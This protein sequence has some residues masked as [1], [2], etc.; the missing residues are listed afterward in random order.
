MRQILFSVA[1]SLL[2]GAAEAH[3]LIASMRRRCQPSPFQSTADAAFIPPSIYHPQSLSLSPAR[4]ATRASSAASKQTAE[5]ATRRKGKAKKVKQPLPPRSLRVRTRVSQSGEELK[6]Y[7]TSIEKKVELQKGPDWVHPSLRWLSR[8]TLDRLWRRVSN[9]EVLLTTGKWGVEATHV[10]SLRDLVRSHG[11]VKVK[12]NDVKQLNST[13]TAIQLQKW[14]EGVPIDSGA[15]IVQVKGKFIQFALP[16][17]LT[18]LAGDS[19]LIS[20]VAQGG[21][22]AD[23]IEDLTNEG[24][25]QTLIDR[26][27][28]DGRFQ[29]EIDEWEERMAREESDK[30]RGVKRPKGV[31]PAGERPDAELLAGKVGVEGW[32]DDLVKD[33]NRRRVFEELA[34]EL[35]ANGVLSRWADDQVA[36]RG[37]EAT[38]ASNLALRRKESESDNDDEDYDY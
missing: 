7:E 29:R 12:D 32:Y 35:T 26:L 2:Y 10:N 17:N 24:V 16:E 38:V 3:S 15:E 23:L 36:T 14:D 37:I 6:K 34:D 27:E 31:K 22:F 25:F 33:L 18:D 4:P 9:K 28:D 21:A 20:A 5:R 13:R 19:D 1:V 30:A 11:I 8:A